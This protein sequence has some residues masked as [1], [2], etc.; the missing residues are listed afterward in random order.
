MGQWGIFFVA[1][2]K[3]GKGLCS[4]GDHSKGVGWGKANPFGYSR[5]HQDA[6]WPVGGPFFLF[7]LVG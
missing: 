2:R 3:K 7:E 1:A 4:R 6:L 5:V